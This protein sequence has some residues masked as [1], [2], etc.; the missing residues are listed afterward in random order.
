MIFAAEL[1][2]YL[3]GDGEEPS[4]VTQINGQAA[5]DFLARQ[6][7]NVTYGGLQDPDALYNQM[8]FVQNSGAGDDTSYGAFVAGRQYPGDNTTLAFANG[9]TVNQPNVAIFNSRLFDFGG[10][11]DGNS[12]YNLY[13]NATRKALRDGNDIN[14]GSLK[15]R[16]LEE[17][18]Y[19]IQKHQ[20]RWQN[21]EKRQ[22]TTTTA[23]ATTVRASSTV[24]SVTPTASRLTG[25][26]T[27]VAISDDLTLSGYFLDEPGFEDTAVLV[28]QQMS[29]EDP[30]SFQSTMTRFMDACRDQ[31]KKRLVLDVQGNPGGTVSLGYEIFKQLFP[32]LYPYGAGTLRAHEGLDT[33]GTFYTNFTSQLFAEQPNNLTLLQLNNYYKQFSAE[34]FANASGQLFQSWP[35]LYGPVKT[36]KENYTNLIRWDLNDT[37]FN[38]ASGNIVISGFGN[39]TNIAASPFTPD[40]IILLSDGRCSSTCTILSHLLKWQGKVKSIAVGG[41]PTNGA[42]QAVGGVKGSQVY[43]YYL[44]ALDVYSAYNIADQLGYN[45]QVRAIESSSIL[46][47]VLNDSDYIIYRGASAGRLPNA[48]Q[49]FQFN[50]QNNVAENDTSYTPLQFVYEAADCRLWYQPQH[51]YD[52]STL[53]TTVAA[54]AFG[55]NNTQKYSLCVQGSTNAPSSLSGNATLFNNGVPDN[56]TSFPVAAAGSGSGG[57][58]NNGAAQ[59]TVSGAATVMVVA[60]LLFAL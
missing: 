1:M 11:V 21:F 12:Y 51:L 46:G 14:G 38:L 6:G 47:P 4:A 23:R 8:L 22:Q 13:C 41:R 52:I 18:N 29:E 54:Q 19:H 59:L 45:D 36:A 31:N 35:A 50:F 30:M 32:N 48:L 15:K 53:W 37:N 55:L 28:L 44:L 34:A 40:N 27:P 58:D 56:V 42:M 16:S 5:A 43:Q 39:N 2:Y 20:K 7:Q 25:Y 3:A 9:T 17:A 10:L 57:G 49:D 33:L 60:A 24:R 26:P